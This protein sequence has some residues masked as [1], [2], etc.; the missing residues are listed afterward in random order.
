MAQPAPEKG[1]LAALYDRLSL[2]TVVVVSFVFIV[3]MA[4]GL[5]WYVSFRNG[6]RAV[7]ELAGQ[8]MDEIAARVGDRLRSHLDLPHTINQ[9][10]ADAIAAGTL[11]L[12]DGKQ[13][14]L[15]FWRLIKQFEGISYIYMG[16]EHGGFFGARRLED[17][18]VELIA[19]DRLTGGNI[20]YIGV[21]DRG[22]RTEV[23]E[24][25]RGY[26]HKTRPW[27]T[28]AIRSRKAVW[29]DIFVDAGGGGL[30]IGAAL[31]VYGEEGNL[32]GVLGCSIIFTHFNDFLRTLKVGKSGATCVLERSGLI[33]AASTP[34]P[35]VSEDRNRIAA[36]ES[37]EPLLKLTGRF[38]AERFGDLSKIEGPQKVEAQIHGKAYFVQVTPLRD[39]RGIDWLI[40]IVV[41]EDDYMERIAANNRNTIIL[42]AM[43][44]IAASLGGVVISRRFTKPILRLN[45]AARSLAMGD[46]AQSVRIDRSDELGELGRSFNSMAEQLRDAFVRLESKV[47]QRTAELTTANREL[48]RRRAVEAQQLAQIE[49]A[50]EQLNRELTDAGDYVK[51]L[52]PAPL[53]HGPVRT[54]WRFVSSAGLGGD[55]LGYHWVDDD[56]FAF[57]VVDV[58]GHGVG[59]ALHSVSVINVLRS[60][61]LH[62]TDFRQPD[63]VLAEFNKMFPMEK[64][65]EMYFT[66]W[67]GV[68][69]RPSKSLEYASAGHPPA[70]LLYEPGN[71]AAE[72]M[73]LQTPNLFVG[74][75]PD[76]TF[77]K[78]CVRIENPCRLYV[79]SD[80]VFEILKDGE[81]VWDFNSFVQFMGRSFSSTQLVLDRLLDQVMELSGSESLDDDFSIVEVSI[82]QKV[83]DSH[84]DVSKILKQPGQDF[85]RF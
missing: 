39:G 22:I 41:P 18:T 57:Y 75:M 12:N 53:T 16:H 11:D 48:I 72:P 37:R 74:G 38:L 23:K 82:D 27:Y 76:L 7:N 50:L 32:L 79:F 84:R 20:N 65:N 14:E 71:R 43:A 62:D 24:V 25:L 21:N 17:G 63:Q 15:H 78:K 9:I 55:S 58:C 30:T 35:V 54:D 1:F 51:S 33:V 31:P 68:Y 40:T 77:R 2:Q 56:H 8:L 83:E 61:S 60:Q 73:L 52:L 29:S 46:W 3:V 66:F 36:A 80:G 59:A 44:L 47:A 4:V 64:H 26:D 42:C 10:T 49:L 6:E 19:T 67:Y 13:Q 70:L 45:D 81:P 34:D 28:S 85:P 5:T 69:H